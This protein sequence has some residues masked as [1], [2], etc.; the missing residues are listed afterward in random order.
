[1]ILGTVYHL[2]D[3]DPKRIR[4]SR[5]HVGIQVGEGRLIWLTDGEVFF[6]EVLS[7]TGTDRERY[8]ITGFRYRIRDGR[9]SNDG[10]AFQAVYTPQPDD[11][12]PWFRFVIDI[13]VP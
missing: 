13:R 7:G 12:P 9:L 10:D 2:I 1:M 11:R 6:E 4:P 3:G 5:P 8:A